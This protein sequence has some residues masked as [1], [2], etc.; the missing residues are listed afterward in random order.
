MVN[1]ERCCGTGPV[2]QVRGR[3][4]L[5]A[6]RRQRRVSGAIPDLDRRD[7]LT[8]TV[9]EQVLAP[10]TALKLTA[11]SPASAPRP[12]ALARHARHDPPAPVRQ[13]R[14]GPD[15]PAR[16]ERRRA[17]RNGLMPRPS[18][19]SSVCPTAWC[20]CAPATWALAPP[21]P[22]TSKSGCPGARPVPRDQL[23]LQLRGL[24]GPPHAGPLQERPGQERVRA[25]AQWFRPGSGRTLVAV[26]ENYQREQTAALRCR[27]CCDLTLAAWK[28]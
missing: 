14:D 10:A 28:F 4:V 19:R 3:H 26:L 21:R 15:R 11:H 9:R 16:A 18:C 24:P 22:M 2:A 5:G 27:R 1:R 7:P 8:N 17:R 25:H 6:A 12:A 13:G 23:L 20:C